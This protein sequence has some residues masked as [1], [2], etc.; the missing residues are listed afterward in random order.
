MNDDW[1]VLRSEPDSTQD[2]LHPTGWIDSI[3]GFK[4]DP[5]LGEHGGVLID[6]AA[7]D[8]Y[9]EDYAWREGKADK[10][11]TR[12]DHIDKPPPTKETI[13]RW[14]ASQRVN[15]WFVMPLRGIR[16]IGIDQAEAPTEPAP[17]VFAPPPPAT[18]Q[19]ADRSEGQTLDAIIETI[20]L[21]GGPSMGP[22]RPTL[23]KKRAYIQANEHLA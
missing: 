20:Q 5:N 2:F 8:A 15:G 16:P 18:T 11:I 3:K 1:V 9:I 17:V 4:V 13:A 12:A 21:A 19:S 22:G 7:R 23:A 14:L 6:D 10:R